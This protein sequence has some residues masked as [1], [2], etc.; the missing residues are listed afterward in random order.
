MEQVVK[1][2][3]IVEQMI[4][5][6][7]PKQFAFPR[8]WR[9]TDAEMVALCPRAKGCIEFCDGISFPYGLSVEGPFKRYSCQ[10]NYYAPIEEDGTLDYANRNGYWERAC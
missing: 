4:G 2:D 5:M 9:L 8:G 3:E 6:G 1:A 7:L 10:W